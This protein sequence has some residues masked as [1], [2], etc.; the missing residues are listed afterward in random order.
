MK[1]RKKI[2]LFILLFLILI[3]I[4]WLFFSRI[5]GIGGLTKNCFKIITAVIN[6]ECF[7]E[8]RKVI[9]RGSSLQGLI[10]DGQTVKAFLNY[11]NCHKIERGDVVLYNFAGKKD[12]VIKIVK[13]IDGDKFNLKKVPFA[14]AGQM[15]WY[16]LINNEIVKNAQGESYLIGEQGYSMLS[17]YEKD[18]KGKIPKDAYLLLGNLIGGSLDSTYFGL[19]DKSDIIGKVE[20]QSNL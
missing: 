3:S 1:K 5:V 11:Y 15:G 6:K 16:I 18:Y 10:E 2:V 9:V 14:N 13:G 12:P 19:I 20:Y 4:G 7:I 8:E 17:L